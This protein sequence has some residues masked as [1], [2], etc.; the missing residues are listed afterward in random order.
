MDAV[1]AALN[2]TDDQKAKQADIKKERGA[3][4]KELRAAL[5]EVLTP[6]QCDQLKKK[7]AEAKKKPAN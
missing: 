2:L 5:M 1:T 6:E 4:E 7:A 3:L